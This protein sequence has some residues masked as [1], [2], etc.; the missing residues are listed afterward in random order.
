[1]ER[2]LGQV[3]VAAIF[4]FSC[5]QAGV[6]PG[7]RDEVCGAEGTDEAI[8]AGEIA[9]CHPHEPHRPMSEQFGAIEDWAQYWL[10]K[11]RTSQHLGDATSLCAHAGSH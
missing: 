11:D 1:M 7:C 2:K 4:P 8:P 10:M 9:R 6:I 5:A 3:K